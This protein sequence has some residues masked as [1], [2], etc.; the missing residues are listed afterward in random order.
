M[1]RNGLFLVT[2]DPRTSPRPAEAVRIAA[3]VNAWQ[4]GAIHI[5]LHGPAVLAIS[6]ETGELVDEELFAQ[7][8]P[9]FQSNGGKLYLENNSDFIGQIAHSSFS[10]TKVA[11]GEL[12]RLAAST[13]WVNRF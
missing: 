1:P 3:G 12:A 10:C 13:A 11:V 8:L 7:Y 6:E 9:V 5:Y 4:K 2:S